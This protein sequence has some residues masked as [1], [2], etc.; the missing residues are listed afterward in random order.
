[1]DRIRSSGYILHFTIRL[2]GSKIC[3]QVLM[4]SIS[5]SKRARTLRRLS[6]GFLT[7]ALVSVAALFVLTVSRFVAPSGLGY[8]IVSLPSFVTAAVLHFRARAIE[9]AA[10]KADLD[11]S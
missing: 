3:C 1:M 5:P 8:V 7:F 4:P 10:L 9:D 11:T 2:H 6:A